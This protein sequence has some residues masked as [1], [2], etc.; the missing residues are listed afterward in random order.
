LGALDE[1]SIGRAVGPA[2]EIHGTGSRNFLGPSGRQHN[3][4]ASSIRLGWF[5][6]APAAA[7]ASKYAAV[8]LDRSA[9]DQVRH[10]A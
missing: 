1:V 2:D 10:H 6:A 3:V 5:V 9:D 7:D 8:L 4:P